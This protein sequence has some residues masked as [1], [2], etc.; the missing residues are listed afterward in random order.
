ML[1]GLAV[2]VLGCA[3]QSAPLPADLETV[4]H[5]N[6]DAIEATA[7]RQLEGQRSTLETRLR[8]GGEAR[9]LANAFGS[10]GELYHTYELYA[11]AATCYRNAER[12]DSESFLWPYY[13]GVVQQEEGDL[14]AAAASLERALA[15]QTDDLPAQRRLAEVRLALGEVEAAG[16]HFAPLVEK[17]PFAAAGHFGL[18]RVALAQGEADKAIGHFEATLERQPQAGSVR[19][20]LAMAL[21]ELEREEEAEA[22]LAEK[23]VGEVSSP[24]RLMQRLES[25]AVS[26]GAYLKRGNRALVAGRLEDAAEAFRKAVKADPTSGEIRRNL[27]GVLLRQ[28][29]IEEAVEEL[30]EGVESSPNDVWLHFDLGNALL[31]KQLAS[32]AVASFQRAVEIDP[33]L[34]S[35]HFNL[36]NAL[37]GLQR[38]EEARPHL[39][40]VARQDPGNPRARYLSGMAWHHQGRSEL[41]I[42]QLRKLLEEDPT[43]T[44]ARMGL[45]SI[46]EEIK[47]DRGAV[48]AYRPGLDLD[49]PPEEKSQLINPLAK[50]TWRLGQPDLAIVYW[51]QG[52]ELQPESSEAHTNLANALQLMG[53]R[54]EALLLFERAVELDPQNA[55]AWLSEASLWILNKNFTMARQRLEAALRIAPEHPGLNNTLARLLATAP[56]SDVR[57]GPL[58]VALARKA[59]GLENSVENAETVGMALAEAG[60][61]EEAIRWQRGVIRQAAVAGDRAVMRRLMTNLKIYESRQRV[62]ISG[63]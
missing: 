35:A 19:H 50:I 31:Q 38:W 28:N 42:Q 59:Y 29:K 2:G 56:A 61:F 23:A 25:L 9:P 24:D 51:R 40:A 5:P 52:I 14:P 26:S 1:V 20:S 36:A 57:N 22:Q 45:G 10:M 13:L 4:E 32:Q 62:R 8:K 48:R 30:R 18:G 12:L 63:D 27:A 37:I 33:K 11:P 44:V 58:A 43:N 6:L 46:M 16:Q 53:N 34:T 15:L 49:I 60:K 47:N 55:T 3:E 21:R 39:E 41:G 17:A 54:D 7:R